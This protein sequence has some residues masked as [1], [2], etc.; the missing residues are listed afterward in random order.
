M[1][2]PLNLGGHALPIIR[3]HR[4]PPT[5]GRMKRY[6][7]GTRGLYIE[8]VPKKIVGDASRQART[9]TIFIKGRRVRASY[10]EAALLV[11]LFENLGHVVPYGRLCEVIGHNSSRARR[12]YSAA[13]H[14]LGKIHAAAIQGAVPDSRGE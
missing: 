8:V 6:K 11:C 2:E 7:I 4:W 3:R 12:T 9:P 1:I 10:T 13:I 5:E 14:D